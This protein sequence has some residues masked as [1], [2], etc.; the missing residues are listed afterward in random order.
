M[1]IR[2]AGDHRAQKH[3]RGR[4]LAAG[5][6]VAVAAIISAGIGDGSQRAEAVTSTSMPRGNVTSNGHVFTP[7]VSQDFDKAA[8]LGTFVKNYGSSWAGYSGFVDTSNKGLY[9]PNVVLS[10]GSGRLDWDLRTR[11]GQPVVAA[12]MPHG[13][14]PQT[15]GRYAVRFRADAVPGYKMAFLLWP[16]SNNWNDGEIDWPDGVLGG[17]SYAASAIR[18][19]L[20]SS[21]PTFEGPPHSAAPTMGTGWHTA[22]TEWTPGHVRWYM[23]GRLIGQTAKTSG[24][25]TKPMRWTLQV[26]TNTDRTPVSA[27]ASGHVQVDWV[28]QYR[29]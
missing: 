18:G 7:V 3:R 11:A 13:Y 26:E 22:V 9:N 21:G 29:Y 2:A 20:S 24:V 14:L 8:P 5:T 6:L 28:V 10:A 27:T 25:P 15:Y 17:K 12:P 4:I 19:T 23:D 16:T 1:H